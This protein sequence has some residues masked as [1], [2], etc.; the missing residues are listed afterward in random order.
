V[1]AG[2]GVSPPPLAPRRLPP[3][4]PLTMVTVHAHK[5]LDSPQ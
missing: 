3:R 5:Q 2:G 4:R 1:D